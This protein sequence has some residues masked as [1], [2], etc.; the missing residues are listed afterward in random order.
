[1]VFSVTVFSVIE[2]A[3]TDE[4]L[5]TVLRP[6]VRA[7]MPVLDVLRESDPLGLQQR[8]SHRPAD[9]VIDADG[10]T[11]AGGAH[12]AERGAFDRARDAALD[13]VSSVRV[14][15]TPAWSAMDVAQRT[16]WWIGRVGRFTALLAA[17]P[18]IG[19]ALADRLPVQDALGAAG[20]GLLL[21]AIAGEHGVRDED[22]QIRLM[23]SVLFGR[24]VD[25]ALGHRP[26]QRDVDQRS[27]ELTA[28]L[29]TSQRKHGRFTLRAV[30][31]TVWRMGRL[32]WALGDELGRRPQGRWYHQALGMLPVVGMAGD[33]LG[34]RSAL[35]RVA[36]GARRWIA[37]YPG[38]KDGSA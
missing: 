25:A 12:A 24:T 27:A 6:F 5:V 32:L 11:D 21:C 10:V 8:M 22:D 35:R 4:Q 14:P 18:G 15:G 16:D 2:G 33:Y 31:G 1:M 17:V 9:G 23:A 26:D 3:V 38:V 30:A 28:E 20:Q 7:T 37:T 19:G 13:W 36:K 29:A 34:E